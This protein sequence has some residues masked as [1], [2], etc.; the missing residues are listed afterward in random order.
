MVYPRLIALD[1]DGTLLDGNS[2]VPEDFWPLLKRAEELGVVI[3]PAS[4]RQLATLQDQ[5]G[6]DLSFIAE[7]GT[8]IAHQG[9]I[10]DVSVLPDDAVY[11]ILDALQSVTVEHDVVLCTPT[12]GYVSEDANPDTF[13][14]L[15]KY[16]YSRESVADLRSM[17][18]AS[19]IIKVAIYCAA[20]SEEFIAPVIFEAIPDHNVAVSGQAWV[21]I[22]PAGANKGA[23]LHHMTKKLGI[24]IEETAAFGDYL[25]DFELLQEAGTA[26]A[27]DNAHPKLKEIADLIAPS[28]LDHGVITVLTEWFDKM[29]AEVETQRANM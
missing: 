12:V 22:M 11:R 1:M 26:V 10:I 5:F 27:M 6:N 2:Q 14:Q 25:N 24:S 19:D 15:E 21:D 7:N 8:A 4:G 29:Q 17:V 13:T 16:Y 28:N 20:G 9:K 23:A 3:A 18:E